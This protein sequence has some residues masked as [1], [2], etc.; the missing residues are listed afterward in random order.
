LGA[1]LFAGTFAERKG[2]SNRLW[3][4]TG[5]A[6]GKVSGAFGSLFAPTT[7][8]VP[9]LVR[10]VSVALELAVFLALTALVASFLDPHFAPTSARGVGVFAGMFIALAVGTLAYV[11]AQSSIARASGVTG[12]FQ[13]RPGYWLV[14]AIGVLASRVIGFVPGFL[15]G[16][17]AGFAVMGAVEGANRRDGMRALIALLT[18]LV[19]GLLCWLLTIPTDLALK[20]LSLANNLVSGGLMAVISAA[21]TVFLLVFF[22][23]LWQT[24]LEALPIRGLSGWT[25]F[26]HNRVVWFAVFAVT[27]FLAVHTLINPNATAVQMVDNRALLVI[28][29]VLALYSAAAVGTWL[30]FNAGQLRGE[31]GIPKRGTLAALGLTIL[32]WLCLC[33]FGAA[34]AVLRNLGPK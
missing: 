31:S 26:T 29:L 17:P 6:A 21:Q 4:A 22:V 16:L 20:S 2:T 28:V 12:V 13:I 30:L 23:A 24:F 32:V 19:V 18:P 11:L 7:W 1:S 10:R 15:F 9:P 27:A 8:P 25:L 5:K 34:L 14:V 3:V 33:G